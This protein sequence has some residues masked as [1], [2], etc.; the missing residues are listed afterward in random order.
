MRSVRVGVLVVA[1]TVGVVLLVVGQVLGGALFLIAAGRVAWR[2]WQLRSP[3]SEAHL[4]QGEG[5]EAE[6]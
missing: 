1:I 3:G 2:L 5:G 4:R 6:I